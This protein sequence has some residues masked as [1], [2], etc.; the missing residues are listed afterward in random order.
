MTP[1]RAPPSDLAR[2]LET[3]QRL[4]ERL[5]TAR[6]EAEGLVAQAHEAAGHEEATLDAQLAEAGRQLDE[7]LAAEARARVAEIAESAE[8]QVQAYERVSA[9]RL[10][11][12]ARKLAERFLLPEGAA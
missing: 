2:L 8:R 3:E 5:R 9:T 12:V 7:R 11:A 1:T 4:E 6:A 10:A